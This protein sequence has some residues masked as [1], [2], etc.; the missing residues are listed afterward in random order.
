MQYS[1]DNIQITNSRSQSGVVFDNQRL[2]T[3][4]EVADYLQC[5]LQHIYNL[6]WRGEIPYVKVGGLLRFQKEQLIE[7]LHERSTP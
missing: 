2:L 4:K 1:P 3:A 6:V 5:S 7:W